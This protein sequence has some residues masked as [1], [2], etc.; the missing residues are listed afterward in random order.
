MYAG[1]LLVFI[2][3]DN[4]FTGLLYSLIEIL[5]F[6]FVWVCVLFF[7]HLVIRVLIRA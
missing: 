6:L 1:R 4:D 3:T 5:F 7:N 2:K